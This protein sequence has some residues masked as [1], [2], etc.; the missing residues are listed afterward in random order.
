MSTQKVYDI[1]GIG[2]G[3][4]NL[5]LAALCSTIPELN[6]L[7]IDQNE[8]FNWHPGMMPAS[9]RLQVPFYA[10]LVT[11]ADPCNKF[12]YMCFLK[13]KKRMFRF[14]IQENYFIKRSEYNEYCRWVCINSVTTFQQ[15]LH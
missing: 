13:A 6:C 7:F 3:P 9:S 8:S 5:G 14:A 12:S 15:H 4:F 11:L 1:I 2:V 10:D